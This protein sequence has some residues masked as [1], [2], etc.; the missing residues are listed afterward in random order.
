MQNYRIDPAS[1]LPAYR[2]L[3]QLIRS[4]I[5]SG[6][7]PPGSRLPTVRRLSEVLG[8]ARGTIKHAYDEL[9]ALGAI[10]MTRGR[11]T[12]VRNQKEG[13]QSR[14]D[15]AMEA[16]DGLLEELLA[17]DFSLGEIGIFFELKLRERSRE[18][19]EIRVAF[20]EEEPELLA[21]VAAQLKAWDGP[22]AGLGIQ[23]W[24]LGEA[25]AN[26]C[27]LGEEMDLILT[28]ESFFSRLEP[29]VPEKEK[30]VKVALTLEE[31]SL[32]QI[33]AAEKSLGESAPAGPGRETAESFLGETGQIPGEKEEKTAGIL[34]A[35][36]AFA[37]R[38]WA[39]LT[40]CAPSLP[41]A[42][43]RLLT[44]GKRGSSP[45]T[46]FPF[47]AGKKER[48]LPGE[49]GAP[50][51]EPSELA[52]WLAAK[53]AVFLPAGYEAFCREGTLK[54]LEEAK[55][56]GRLVLC[57]YRLDEGSLLRVGERVESLRQKGFYLKERQEK[58]FD[59]GI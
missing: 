24:L 59:A 47:A 18:E 9:E 5:R 39:S 56:W 22:P 46:S 55:A 27:K 16:I 1:R 4:D 31:A 36:P 54:C 43:Q 50:F 15:Q 40:H 42:E 19:M 38:L 13:S 57:A 45:L 30:L 3:V 44:A 33:F 34:T 53:R 41:P 2:Q 29:L 58:A 25:L 11:G 23:P 48:A 37:R 8:L 6:R 17:L 28:T 32:R 7:L 26:P 35:S 10:E 12:F 20:V 21:Q 14:K 52:A 49:K 51:G